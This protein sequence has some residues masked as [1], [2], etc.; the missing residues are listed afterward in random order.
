MKPALS[1]SHLAPWAGVFLGAAAWFAQHQTG[2]NAV[3]WDCRLGGPWLTAATGLA[4]AA[5]VVAGGLISWKA[6]AAPPESA[7]RPETRAFAAYVGAGT[8]AIFLLAVTLQTLS[9]FI[10]PGCFR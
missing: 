4:C 6:R 2:S 3:Y 1:R 7:D 8:A 9:G 10:V 5:V